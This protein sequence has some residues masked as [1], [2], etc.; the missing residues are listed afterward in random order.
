MAAALSRRSVSIASS[1]EEEGACSDARS[2]SDSTALAG[3]GSSGRLSLGGGLKGKWK[4]VQEHKEVVDQAKESE[5]TASVFAAG[6]RETHAELKEL[7]QQRYSRIE[8]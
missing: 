7:L 3:T 8:A 5:D 4:K 6:L 1:R 2:R